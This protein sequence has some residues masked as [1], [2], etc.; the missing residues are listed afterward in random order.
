MLKAFKGLLGGVRP[1]AYVTLPAARE[2]AA[3]SRDRTDVVSNVAFYRYTAM[4]TW[5]MRT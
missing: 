4:A 2:H 5:H 3:P 1:H